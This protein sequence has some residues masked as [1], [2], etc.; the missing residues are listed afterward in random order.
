M[1]TAEAQEI[2]KLRAATSECVNAISRNRGLQQFRV[3]G[4]RKAQAV[5]LCFAIV[6]NLRRSLSLQATLAPTP[7]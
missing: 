3:R 1:G 4:R 2:Y 7:G 5:A 6:H